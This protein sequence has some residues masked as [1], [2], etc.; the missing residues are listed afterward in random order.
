M[1]GW[2]VM[3]NGEGHVSKPYFNGF[4]PKVIIE[5]VE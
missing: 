2:I 4:H 3:K 1:K 5:R